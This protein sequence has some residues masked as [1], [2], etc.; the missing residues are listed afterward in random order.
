MK[1]QNKKILKRSYNPPKIE[2]V[3]LDNEIS[4]VLES[5]PPTGPGDE[6]SLLGFGYYNNDPYKINL[7]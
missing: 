3:K 6:T 2:Q 7:G 5:T 4:M 1:M